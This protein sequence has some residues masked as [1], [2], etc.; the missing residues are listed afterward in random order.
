MAVIA[1]VDCRVFVI[2]ALY[3]TKQAILPRQNNQINFGFGKNSYY[4]NPHN[5]LMAMQGQGDD[6]FEFKKETVDL[7]LD[8][9]RCGE[10]SLDIHYFYPEL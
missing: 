4:A 5:I 2:S 1:K 10:E 8:L 6:S 9:R 7:M 3:K